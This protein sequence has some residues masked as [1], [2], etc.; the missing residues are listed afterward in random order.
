MSI[1][2][3]EQTIKHIQEMS[4]MSVRLQH[5]RA[6]GQ[7]NKIQYKSSEQRRFHME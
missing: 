5:D 2:I 7:A 4:L 6:Q 1:E 3:Q